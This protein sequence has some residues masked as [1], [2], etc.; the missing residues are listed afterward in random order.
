MSVISCSIQHLLLHQLTV[1]H[2]CPLK[3]VKCDQYW[4]I[5]GTETYGMIQVTMLDAVEL[6]TY[7]VR[8]FALY[9]VK[10][11]S[12]YSKFPHFQPLNLVSPTL[13]KQNGSSEKRELRQFQFMAWPDHGVPEYPTPIL[14]LLRRVKACNPPD[15]GPMVVHCRLELVPSL[16]FTADLFTYNLSC[17][18][19]S[20]RFAWWNW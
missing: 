20:C 9:K 13:L 10:K 15:A 7:S 5:R 18:V 3:Q 1:S 16:S 12:H 11:S 6:A 19:N 4:P 14:A 17:K 2:S 8:T